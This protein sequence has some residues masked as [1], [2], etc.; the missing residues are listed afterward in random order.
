MGGICPG[1]FIF[2]RCVVHTFYICL[3]CLL[4]HLHTGL[5]EGQ[6]V[7]LE[8]IISWWYHLLSLPHIHYL[9][10]LGGLFSFLHS[11]VYQQYLNPTGFPPASPIIHRYC[12]SHSVQSYS[13]HP[14]QVSLS[15]CLGFFVLYR[16]STGDS[17][18]ITVFFNREKINLYPYFCHIPA[19]GTLVGSSFSYWKGVVSTIICSFSFQKEGL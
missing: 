2:I 4:R 16:C 8:L 15:F 14:L 12:H 1:F 6:C 7:I 19:W 9:H 5:L 13:V 18:W 17:I 3:W 10:H 11:K